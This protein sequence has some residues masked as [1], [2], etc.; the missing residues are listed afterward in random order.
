M[1]HS[2]LDEITWGSE[3]TPALGHL[4]LQMSSD[5]PGLLYYKQDFENKWQ[6]SLR[7]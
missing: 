4:D 2:Q 1:K 6:S 7:L 3:H 5:Q